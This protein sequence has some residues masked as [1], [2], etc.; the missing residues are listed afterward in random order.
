[1]PATVGIPS[2]IKPDED[3]VAIAPSGVHFLSERGHKVLVQRGAGNGSGLAD[4]EF[5]AAGAEIVPTAAEVFERSSIVTKVKE[6]LPE[7]YSL[8]RSGQVLFTYF[9]F[10]AS[11]E[12]TEAMIASGATCLAYETIRDSAGGLPLLTPMS[13]VAGRMSVLEGAKCLERSSGGRGVLISGVP[14]VESAKVVI[15]GGGVVGFN[16]AQIA[17]GVGAQVSI[18]DIKAARLRFLYDNLP[19]NVNTLYSNPFL[20]QK[21]NSPTK[22]SKA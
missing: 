9:H 16:A 14:G 10:A 5:A 11:R 19:R 12:L 18:F 6:P 20:I 3:R 22:R 2:E 7:E 21:K 13:E 4:E 8:I 15:L 17:A 1:M